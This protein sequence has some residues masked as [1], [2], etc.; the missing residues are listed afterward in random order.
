MSISLETIESQNLK[1][2][3][4]ND[5]SNVV[6]LSMVLLVGDSDVTKNYYLF[7]KYINNLSIAYGEE[8]QC[9]L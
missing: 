1:L 5:S 4:F 7:K 8:V 6:H 9:S 2:L 3:M